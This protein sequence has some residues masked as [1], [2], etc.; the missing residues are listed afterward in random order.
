M[1]QNIKDVA[2]G[3]AVL[4]GT[5][6]ALY[7]LYKVKQGAEKAADAVAAVVKEDLNPASDRNLAY[8][9]VNAVGGAL[10]GQGDSF[11]L[12]SWLYELTH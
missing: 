7:A 8:R 9:G 11:S 4:A 1:R 10:T 2:I 5:G 6:V 3:V 12:G